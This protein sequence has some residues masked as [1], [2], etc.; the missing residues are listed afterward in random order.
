METPLQIETDGQNLIIKPIRDTLNGPK[1]NIDAFTNEVLDTHQET[2][3][4]P[5]LKPVES[6]KGTKSVS[7]TDSSIQRRTTTDKLTFEEFIQLIQGKSLEEA[8]SLFASSYIVD[9]T[10]R[11]AFCNTEMFTHWGNYMAG[12]FLTMKGHKSFN[13]K[14]IKDVLQL[15]LGDKYDAPGFKMSG[16]LTADVAYTSNHHKG[17]PILERVGHGSYSFIGY[18]EGLRRQKNL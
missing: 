18:K 7:N 2:Y 14:Q 15:I 11:T 1:S 8:R 5:Q 9:M 10:E 13:T 3:S 12:Y 16:L 17:F 6:P 4:T